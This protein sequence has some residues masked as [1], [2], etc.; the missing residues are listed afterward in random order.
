MCNFFTT[1]MQ[2]FYNGFRYWC[3]F[4]MRSKMNVF[5]YDWKDI[6]HNGKYKQEREIL[7]MNYNAFQNISNKYYTL[8]NVK[9]KSAIWKLHNTIENA[10]SWIPIYNRKN[11]RFILCCPVY[12]L[13]FCIC[14]TNFMSYNIYAFS[15]TKRIHVKI[16]PWKILA[17]KW[18]YK[19][20][21]TEHLLCCPENNI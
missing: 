4:E 9:D 15:V 5:L 21:Y 19:W 1:E 20:N 11:T 18:N 6:C 12:D 10:I 3:K 2:K 17:N 16:S 14:V 8:K 7:L 13:W